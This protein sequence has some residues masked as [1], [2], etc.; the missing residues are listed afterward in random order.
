MAQ[1]ASDPIPG[2]K[3][4]DN[5]LAFVFVDRGSE[6]PYFA[7]ETLMSKHAE[8]RHIVEQ[9][10]LEFYIHSAARIFECMYNRIIVYVKNRS[11]SI[12]HG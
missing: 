10:L 4:D 6:N 2:V 9:L 3:F 8:T 12:A 11:S 5:L 7:R 1:Y